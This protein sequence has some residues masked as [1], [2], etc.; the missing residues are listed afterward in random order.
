VTHNLSPFFFDLLPLRQPDDAICSQKK[1]L[2]TSA[3]SQ[4][5]NDE[6]LRNALTQKMQFIHFKAGICAEKAL[7]AAPL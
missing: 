6:A 2:G 3:F 5:S 1:G 7:P 4:T